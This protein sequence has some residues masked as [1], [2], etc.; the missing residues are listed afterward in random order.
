MAAEKCKISIACLR[1]TAWTSDERE[2]S[3]GTGFLIAPG[4]LLTALHVIADME[5]TLRDNQ[6][7]PLDGHLTL[8][9]DQPRETFEFNLDA[10]AKS[11]V[12]AR[13][14][15]RIEKYDI[16]EDWAILLVQTLHERPGLPTGLLSTPRHL[17]FWD[18]WGFPDLNP[19]GLKVEGEISDDGLSSGQRS[20][21]IQLY[22]KQGAAGIGAALSGL[23]GAPL[24]VGSTVVGMLQ[25]DI[26]L[27]VVT[28]V[29][30]SQGGTIYALPLAAIQESTTLPTWEDVSIPYL[31]T[32]ASHFV[33]AGK[34]KLT[35]LAHRLKLHCVEAGEDD[36][37]YCVTTKLGRLG[38]RGLVQNLQD[39]KG[40]GLPGPRAIEI[41]VLAQPLLIPESS[42][43][44][45]RRKVRRGERVPV[46]LRAQRTDT[47][48]LYVHRILGMEALLW[49][50]VDRKRIFS[51]LC[52][53]GETTTPD[54]ISQID[55]T[56]E[57]RAD[58][59]NL[60]KEQQ[61]KKFMK[62]DHFALFYNIIPDKPIIDSLTEAFP[63]L[64]L[65]F[66]MSSPFC[67]VEPYFS[68]DNMIF[69]PPDQLLP[70]QERS[71]YELYSRSLKEIRKAY[72]L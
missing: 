11:Q 19:A 13:T 22:C 15:L 4:R 50:E 29:K 5:S 21:R 25:T 60:T 49:E 30:S 39:L 43:T 68:F 18:S 53:G 6:I 42:A 10:Q 2:L 64:H 59:A 65:V 67:S 48:K 40:G 54:I 44:D 24:F 31:S 63:G 33:S 14:P 51:V 71:V 69:I 32:M 55:E 3:R 58:F 38:F 16:E 66:L 9:F 12:A 26:A 23:S 17:R 7:V 72:N 41:V 20:S 45:W 47:A 36:L 34:L 27:E 70:D 52:Q 57:L 8:L 37:A 28:G 62:E 1:V 46:A 61:L 56:L 35:D